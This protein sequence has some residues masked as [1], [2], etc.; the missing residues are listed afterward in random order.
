MSLRTWKKKHYR[1]D[2]EDVSPSDAVAHSLK[3]WQGLRLPV[4]Q[5][6]GLL[7]LD[8]HIE[9][10]EGNIL[11]IDGES[12]AL[13]QAYVLIDYS[14]KECP[15]YEFLGHR[16]DAVGGPYRDWMEDQDPEPMIKALEAIS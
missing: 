11:D 3:K 1:I 13:C 9:D 16:C 12:C 7:V 6:H 15:L 4:L 14:C 10:D 8:D 5:K 2:A